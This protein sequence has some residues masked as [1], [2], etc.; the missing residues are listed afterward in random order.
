MDEETTTK[1]IPDSDYYSQFL[2]TVQ[3][4]GVRCHIWE[5]GKKQE[6]VIQK[7]DTDHPVT[8][9]NLIEFRPLVRR[10]RNAMKVIRDKYGRAKK[11]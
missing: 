11:R 3:S 2:A 6:W 1:P 8:D 9:D 10:E 7:E 4:H 5:N